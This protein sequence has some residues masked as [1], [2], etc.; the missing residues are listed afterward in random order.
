MIY[1]AITYVLPL[2]TALIGLKLPDIDLAP[3]FPFRHRSAWTHG[4]LP[5][6]LI[7]WLDGRYPVYHNAWI[8]M[9]AGI[10]IHLLADCFPRRWHGLAMIN[11]KPINITLKALPSFWVIFSGSVF[12]GYMCWVKF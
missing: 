9:L 5:A 3:V 7:A 8:A 6:L 4:P 10:A 11:L 1:Y 2:I 12:S